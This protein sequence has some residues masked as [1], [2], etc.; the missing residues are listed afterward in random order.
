MQVVAGGID[1]Q[2]RLHVRLRGRQAL[3]AGHELR[4]VLGVDLASEIGR[5]VRSVELVERG[6][7][8]PSGVDRLLRAGQLGEL[9]ADGAEI[10]LDLLDLAL[11]GRGQLVVDRLLQRIAHLQVAQ[12]AGDQAPQS[13]RAGRG[14]RTAWRPGTSARGWRGWPDRAGTCGESSPFDAGMRPDGTQN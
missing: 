11:P 10:G 2:V 14:W 1:G 12:H 13:R 7:E 8:S 6:A 3:D 5:H 4:A 9:V